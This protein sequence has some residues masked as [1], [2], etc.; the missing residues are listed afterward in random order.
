MF[1]T[2][3][4]D[5]KI[6]ELRRQLEAA[7]AE[8]TAQEKREKAELARVQKVAGTNHSRLVLALYELLGVEPEHGTTRTVKG[9]VREV[10]VDKDETLRTQRLYELVSKLVQ[11]VD[12]ALLDELKHADEIVREERRPKPKI[13]APVDAAKDEQDKV[14]TSDDEE[15]PDIS[16]AFSTEHQR[17]A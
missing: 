12:G 17:I 11:N 10:A 2:T 16:D 1:T 8:K 7:E 9:E 15:R 5:E 4:R 14:E 6:E 13:A 3:N